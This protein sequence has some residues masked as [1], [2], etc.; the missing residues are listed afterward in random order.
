MNVYEI[1]TIINAACVGYQ[2]LR[3]V[4]GC[5]GDKGSPEKG[6][7]FVQGIFMENLVKSEDLEGRKGVMRIKKGKAIPVTGRGGP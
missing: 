1:R 6:I 5:E 3:N 4:K 7:I 2:L